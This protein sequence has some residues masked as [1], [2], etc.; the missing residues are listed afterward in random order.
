V[1]EVS[2]LSWWK[3]ILNKNKNT[4][5]KAMEVVKNTNQIAGLNETSFSARS[6]KALRRS[7]IEV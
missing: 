1:D 2:K 5:S 3:N 6:S 4:I 7:V